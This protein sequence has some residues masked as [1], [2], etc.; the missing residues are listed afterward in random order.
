MARLAACRRA[1]DGSYR[2]HPRR[3]TARPHKSLAKL[4]SPGGQQTGARVALTN[5]KVRFNVDESGCSLVEVLVALV[6]LAVALTALAQLFTIAAQSNSIARSGTFSQIL[7]EQKME[8]LRGLAWG[9]DALGLPVSDTTSDT[10][11][12][13]QAATGGTGLAPSPSNTLQAN[14]SGYVDYLEPNGHSLGGGTVIPSNA[15]YIRRWFVEPLPAHP[16]HTLVLQ[17]LVTRRADRGSADAGSVQRLP[18]EARL[19]T[20]KTRKAR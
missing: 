11:V 18:E 17:V 13:P 8:Q 7:A 6:L 19:I 3:G 12:V 10:A 20:L 2:N 4:R 1:S 15:A 9:F 5:G 16:D 14:T